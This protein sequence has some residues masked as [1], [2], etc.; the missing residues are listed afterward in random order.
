MASRGYLDAFGKIPRQARYAIAIHAIGPNI[1]ER[2]RA[3]PGRRPA[4]IAI[5]ANCV[6]CQSHSRIVIAFVLWKYLFGK[7]DSAPKVEGLSTGEYWQAE[8][9][10]AESQH[11]AAVLVA[12]L[13]SMTQQGM[14]LFCRLSDQ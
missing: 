3:A 6:V 12:G 4:H 8:K 14:L 5:V 1:G 13:R 11:L 9:N 7:L 10:G 2:P